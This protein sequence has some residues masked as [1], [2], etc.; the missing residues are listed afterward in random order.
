MSDSYKTRSRN[1]TIRHS[2]GQKNVRQAI[3][4][5]YPAMEIYGIHSGEF[6]F[7]NLL[8]DIILQV[9]KP[10]NLDISTWTMAE[11]EMSRLDHYLKQGMVTRIRFVIDRSFPTCHIQKFK[12]L[13]ET[14]G[15]NNI[16]VLPCHCKFA[17]ILNDDWN[18]AIRTSM[19]LNEN[20]RIENF[21]IS[22]DKELASYMSGIV[23]DFFS[24]P[25]NTKGL[26]LKSI[27]REQRG[28]ESLLDGIPG[29]V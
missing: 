29:L 26:K 4:G 11:F 17:I 10:V 9:G 12:L 25:F 19:N 24:K 20:K 23:D 3:G 27:K 18:I 7:I 13:Q 16:R 1:R 14:L 21:E 2:V 15:V 5:I 8:E 22:D 28:I 6:S